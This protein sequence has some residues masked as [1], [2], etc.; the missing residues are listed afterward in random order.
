M[1][2]F[3]NVFLIM[4]ASHPATTEDRVVKAVQR[5]RELTAQLDERSRELEVLKAQL[6]AESDKHD[7]LCLAAAIALQDLQMPVLQD[8]SGYVTSVAQIGDR[9]RQMRREWMD[10]GVHQTFIVSCMH[11]ETI[12]LEALSEGFVAGFTEAQLQEFEDQAWGPA[13]TLAEKLVQMI[14]PP[15]RE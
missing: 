10:I 7:R 15:E 13:L 8:P 12:D 2:D 5:G 6:Q 14:D 11:Y 3:A 4:L 1:C 9:A